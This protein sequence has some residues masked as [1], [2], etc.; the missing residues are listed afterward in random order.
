MQTAVLISHPIDAPP[1]AVWSVLAD[2]P[3]WPR[4]DPYLTELRRID[5]PARPFIP[6]IPQQHWQIGARWRER[7]RRGPFHPTFQLT[8]C[9]LEYE[10]ELAWET[11]Y[12]FVHVVHRWTIRPGGD[13]NGCLI[14]SEERFTGPA[15]IILAARPLLALFRVRR[16]TQR[17]LAALA[18]EVLRREEIETPARGR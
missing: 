13:G 8:V 3:R 11:R 6:A 18:A 16:M 17:S 15:P 7:A 4:W 9:R 1:R 12:L 2:L 5:L 10:R 14:E